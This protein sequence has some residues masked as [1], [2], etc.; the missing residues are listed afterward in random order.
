[1]LCIGDIVAK[2]TLP[3]YSNVPIARGAV[4]MVPGGAVRSGVTWGREL[5][6]SAG[7]G[8]PGSRSAPGKTSGDGIER[9]NH[10][11]KRATGLSVGKLAAP[12]CPAPDANLAS[13][14]EHRHRKRQSDRH[15]QPRVKNRSIGT[16]QRFDNV[17]T[18]RQSP[19]T[20]AGVK[21]PIRAAAGRF[22]RYCPLGIDISQGRAGAML[23]A[24]APKLYWRDCSVLTPEKPSHACYA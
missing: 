11:T 8:N 10:Q 17:S 12:K 23:A 5:A 18:F 7:A 4:G 16:P 6:G 1:M 19:Q 20:C 3:P 24:D 15:G 2:W 21:H 14:Q 13:G 22:R 9:L